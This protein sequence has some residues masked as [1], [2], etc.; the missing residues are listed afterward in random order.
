M[1]ES[2][3]QQRVRLEAARLGLH[4]WRN[5][6][7]A[8]EDMTGRQI[9]FGLGND[10]AKLNR[11]FK[12]SDLIGIAPTVVSQEMVGQTL[13]VFIALEIKASGWKPKSND[14]REQAQRRFI[15]HVIGC[16]GIAGIINNA[17]QIEGLL[18]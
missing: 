10:S 7:G 2:S 6:S 17:D 5:N 9:R 13:G 4:L 15:D 1:L 11:V 12:S 3:V 8:C 16:G 18:K 14:T